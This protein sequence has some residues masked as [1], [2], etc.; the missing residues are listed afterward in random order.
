MSELAVAMMSHLASP[1]APTGAERSLVVLANGLAARKHRVA[2]TA[3]G[4]SAFESLLAASVPFTRIPC[5][6]AWLSHFEHDRLWRV[7]AKFLRFTAPDRGPAQLEQ[8]IRGVWPDVVHVNCLP[9]VKG[10]RAARK[11]G[12]PV[13]WHIREILPE[14]RRRGWFAKQLSLSANAIVAVS[15]AVASWLKD[16]GLGPMLSVI[17]NGVE[18]P[19]APKTREAA[20]RILGLPVDG[21]IAGLF[22]QVLPH[23]GILEAI[24][25]VAEARKTAP[26]LRLVVAGHGPLDFLAEADTLAERRGLR[27]AYRRLPG[28]ADPSDLFA[29]SDMIL[30]ATKTPDPFP[31][32]VLEAMAWGRPVAAFRSGGAGEM[33]EDGQTG[34]IVDNGDIP[35]FAA[36]IARLANDQGLRDLFGAAG[37][38]R[39]RLNFSIDA[40]VTKMEEV[41]RAVVKR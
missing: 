26:T 21:V 29:A 39:A 16:E 8:W 40:H 7:A 37:R 18:P 36:A 15:E 20:R 19:A 41:Y 4:P 33:V 13:V 9:H 30:L 31:R 17:P 11:A 6:M 14:G 35:G 1:H 3:P 2:V 24:E 38:T 5:R 25:A 27:D 22:G 32:A 12:Y 10:A 28:L 34:F 23:K